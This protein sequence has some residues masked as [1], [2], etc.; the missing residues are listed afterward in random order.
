MWSKWAYPTQVI[1]QSSK[2]QVLTEEQVDSWREKGFAL[3]DG[4]LPSEL[5]DEVYDEAFNKL[6]KSSDSCDFGSDGMMVRILIKH[7]YLLTL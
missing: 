6:S 4:L 5:C 3:V 7:K 1:Q 2:N